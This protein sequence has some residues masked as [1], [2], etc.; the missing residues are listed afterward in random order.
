MPL[1]CPNGGAWTALDNGLQCRSCSGL[2]ACGAGL[3]VQVMD[4]CPE[5]PAHSCNACSGADDGTSY[6]SSLIESFLTGRIA[7]AWAQPAAN[8]LPDNSLS[9]NAAVTQLAAHGQPLA[10]AALVSALENGMP[11]AQA[12]TLA[13]AAG[14]PLD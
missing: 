14:I 7:Y 4:Q 8:T 5:T 12:E 13:A 9:L 2:I 6:L 3:T 1:V 10:V 11:Q